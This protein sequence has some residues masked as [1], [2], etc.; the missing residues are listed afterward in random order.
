MKGVKKVVKVGDSAVAV[1]ADTF[2]HAKS[3]LDAPRSS[4]TKARTRR[5]PSASIAKW[6]AEGLD[7]GP[8]YVGNSNGDTKAATRRRRE[9]DRSHLQLSLTRTTPRWSR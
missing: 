4:G 6:L 7:S 1:V 8:A 2:W 3:A 9:D 5:S